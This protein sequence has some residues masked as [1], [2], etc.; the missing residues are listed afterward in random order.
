[1]KYLKIHPMYL[2]LQDTILVVWY[3]NDGKEHDNTLQ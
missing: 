2:V 3:D 1:M